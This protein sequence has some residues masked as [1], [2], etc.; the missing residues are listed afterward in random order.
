VLC[1]NFEGNTASILM[2]QTVS[3]PESL[4][5][6]VANFVQKLKG[7]IIL[8]ETLQGSTE[9]SLLESAVKYGIVPGKGLIFDFNDEFFRSHGTNLVKK[10]Y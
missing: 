10:Y 5:T 9:L 2:Y 3:L 8:R 4:E 6:R 1:I 7:Q